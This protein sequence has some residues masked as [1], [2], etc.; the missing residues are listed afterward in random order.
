M[1]NAR[2]DLCAE[3]EQG[4]ASSGFGEESDVS[5]AAAEL[6]AGH[7]SSGHLERREEPGRVVL[8]RYHRAFVVA[9]EVDELE[10]QAVHGRL[11]L[12]REFVEAECDAVLVVD[13][14]VD[15]QAA[16]P[17]WELAVE[18]DHQPGDAVSGLDGVVVQ[19]PSGGSPAF[20][21]VEWA[22]VGPL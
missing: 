19:E 14:V 21:G 18:Q 7:R 1:E 15:G 3:V 13:D 11:D 22:V 6:L 10:D 12:R 8:V 9:C 20:V 16:G 2:G 4:R 17:R 5:K